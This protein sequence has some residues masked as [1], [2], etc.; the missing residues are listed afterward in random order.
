MIV[1]NVTTIV[2]WKWLISYCSTVFE[3]VFEVVLVN[4]YLHAYLK[5]GK[6]D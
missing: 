4:F 1:I 5:A 3:E 6:N 2:Y